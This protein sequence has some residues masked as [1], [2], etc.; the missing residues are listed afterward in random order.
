VQSD[1]EDVEELGEIYK[2]IFNKDLLQESKKF[3]QTD[4]NITN[5]KFEN[6]TGLDNQAIDESGNKKIE[7]S[8]LMTA[9]DLVKVFTYIF[10]NH[11][12]IFEYTKFENLKTSDKKQ[13]AINTNPNTQKTYGLLISKTGYTE[14]ALGNLGVIINFAPNENYLVLVLQSGKEERFADIQKLISAIPNF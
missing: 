13:V 4:L 10:D 5:F 3:L 11:R 6:L 7:A 12:N 1:N 8:N 14:T 9:N 2:Q